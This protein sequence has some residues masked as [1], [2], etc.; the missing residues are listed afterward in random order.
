MEAPLSAKI[1]ELCELASKENDGERLIELAKEIIEL[2][3]RQRAH[4]AAT[5]P[6]SP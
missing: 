1:R 4:K 6:K 5:P 2:Y 3:D